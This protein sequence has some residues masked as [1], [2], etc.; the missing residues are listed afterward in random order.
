MPAPYSYVTLAA[1]WPIG[2]TARMVTGRPGTMPTT[3]APGTRS[4]S[5][6]ISVPILS[7]T[8]LHC[9]TRSD[10]TLLFPHL[11]DRFVEPWLAKAARKLARCG[12]KRSGAERWHTSPMSPVSRGRK[13]KRSFS[14]PAGSGRSGRAK[15]EPTL[16]DLYAELLRAARPLPRT[17][18]PLDVEVLVSG[19]V[20]SWWTTTLPGDDPE[21]DHT[22]G[23]IAYAERKGGPAALALLR[24]L[25]A[26]GVRAVD[27]D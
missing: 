4:P 20:G 6:A 15:R 23:L 1:A 27:R 26:L 5:A 14:R 21:A 24:G 13:K 11:F 25:A 2:W 19:L 7:P 8:P 17:D 9:V 12:Q 10:R 3:W 16:E 18:D 22:A